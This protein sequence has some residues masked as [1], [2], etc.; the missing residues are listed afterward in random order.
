MIVIIR[1]PLG[2]GK[3]TVARMLAKKLDA[4]YISID[5]I[6]AEHNLDVIEGEG[7]SLKNFL[8]VNSFINPKGDAVIDG[9]FYHKK[10]IT[11]LT[12]KF[13]D[14]KIFTLKASIETCM[15]R[16]STR[17][18]IYGPDAVVAVHNMVS[19]F[20]YGAIINTEGKSA[21]QVVDEIF[22]LL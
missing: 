6:L 10:Q 14:V 7:I 15:Q 12:S 3:S 9:N 8:K 17:K 21:E 1:G 2:I 16:D 11:D 13:A 20:D 18:K 22:Q 19:R 5:A 4:E